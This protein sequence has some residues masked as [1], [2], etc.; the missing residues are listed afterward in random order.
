MDERDW[1]CAHEETVLFS[2]AKPLILEDAIDLQKNLLGRMILERE[3]KQNWD[4]TGDSQ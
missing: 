3:K 1:K 2:N 4:E